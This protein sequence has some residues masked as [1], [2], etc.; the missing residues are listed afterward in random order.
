M[1]YPLFTG[2]TFFIRRE[3]NEPVD[4]QANIASSMPT[5]ALKVNGVITLAP[6]P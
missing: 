5:K 1:L 6:I 4:C 3:N 2:S